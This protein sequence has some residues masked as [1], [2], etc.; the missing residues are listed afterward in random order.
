MK[1]QIGDP[2]GNL[3]YSLGVHFII[4]NKFFDNENAGTYNNVIILYSLTH[5][6]L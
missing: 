6:K 4:C 2:C 3:N 5:T 1:N